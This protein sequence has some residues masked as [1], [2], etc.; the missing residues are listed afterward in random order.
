MSQGFTL[1]EMIITLLVAAIILTLGIPSFQNSIRNNAM[2]ASTNSMIAS[3]QLA[4]SEAIKRRLPVSVC[5]AP[6]FAAVDVSCDNSA[7]W[8]QGW[9]VFADDNGN[10]AREATEQIIRRER[11]MRGTVNVRTPADQP[12]QNDITYLATGFPALGGLDAAGLMVICDARESDYFGRIIAV[13]QT[14]RPQA[15]LIKDRPDLGET[16]E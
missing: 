12:L 10:G 11:N 5:T 13:P 3:L 2:T 16:C 15:F 1:I 6:D 4:R 8:Q 7:D 9:I 14:G